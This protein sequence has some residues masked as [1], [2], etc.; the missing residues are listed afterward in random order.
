MHNATEPVTQSARAR[1]PVRLVP[2]HSRWRSSAVTYGPVG[3]IV[4][5]AVVLLPIVFAVF[6]NSLFMLAALVWLFML[7]T[8]LRSIWARVH[9]GDVDD[10][11][12]PDPRPDID[13]HDTIAGRTGARRW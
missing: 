4:A 7:P 5:T 3:R 11:G 8:A 10:L 9:I 2:V 12:E 6:V 13:P 1:P